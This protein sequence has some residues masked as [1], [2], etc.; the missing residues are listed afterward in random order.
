MTLLAVPD[1]RMRTAWR[2]WLRNAAVFKR[3]YRF[4]LLAWFIEPLIYL[5]AMGLGLGKYLES[6]GGVR[7]IDFIAP[8]LLAVSAMY[9][10]TFESTWGAYFKMDRGR[11]YDACAA[12]PLSYEDVALGEMLWAATRAAIY[13]VAFMVIAIPFHVFHSWWGVLAPFGLVLVGLNF[14]A[15]G[16]LYT[17][18]VRNMDYLAYYW[19]LFLTPMFMFSGIFFPLD[20]L[21]AWLRVVTW[22]MPLRHATDMMR[23]LLSFG[24]IAGAAR[25]AAWLAAVTLLLLPLPLR[26]LRRRMVR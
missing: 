21:P 11:I 22:F 24:D 17:Y 10:A 14:A 7:Y 4:A 8:G 18:R 26:M 23:S 2:Y 19:T 25:A 1:V 5:L 13:G 20:R 16:L 12:T 15:T 6:I 9:G 3:T